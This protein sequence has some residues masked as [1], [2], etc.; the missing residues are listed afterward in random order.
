MP[1]LLKERKSREVRSMLVAD[2]LMDVD[3]DAA[4][5]F[6]I[7]GRGLDVRVALT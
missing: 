1:R 4:V 2:D 3:E 6:R 5:G 7:K